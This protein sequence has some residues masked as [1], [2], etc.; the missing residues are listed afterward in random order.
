MEMDYT[1]IN[2][3]EFDGLQGE[4]LLTKDMLMNLT[5]L[6]S[7]VHKGI[8]VTYLPFW[9]TKIQDIIEVACVTY[10]KEDIE[11]NNFLGVRIEA[12]EDVVEVSLGLVGHE[13]SVFTISFKIESDVDG[14]QR[15]G[16]VYQF[17][18]I[19]QTA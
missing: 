11:E 10:T 2:G 13:E 14:I 7:S 19:K 4:R 9:A 17:D 8:E 15:L 6:S 1:K 16:E 12:L 5:T 3:N 18:A